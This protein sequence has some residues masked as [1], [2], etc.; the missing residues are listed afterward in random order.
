MIPRFPFRF[1][2]PRLITP[3]T[4]MALSS[5][6]TSAAEPFH[7][8]HENILGTSLDLQ[9]AVT[10]AKQATAA[11]AAVLGEIERL[12]RI[13]SGYDPAS[14]LSR[15]NTAAQPMTYSQEMIDVL[16]AYDQW[17]LKSHGAYN[18][19][20][21]DLIALWTKAEKAGA[22]PT[23]AEL[24]PV[25]TPL[26]RPGWQI[27]A[28]TRTVVR[29]S[30][31]GTLNVNSLGKG[32][33]VTKAAVAARKV[34]PEGAGLLVN[35]G[36][37]IFASGHPVPETPWEIGVANPSHNE[38]NSPPL[39]TVHL[40]NQ[41]VSTS[42]AYE[43]GFNIKGRHYSH[44]LDPRS[45]QATE[46][47]ASATVVA[48]NNASSNAMAT[49]LCV[50]KPEE[51]L[52]LV[53][54]YPGAEC[55]IIAADGR[56]LRSPGFATLES[57]ATRPPAASGT[58]SKTGNWPVGYQVSISLELK[59]SGSGGKREKPPF[60]A[61]WAENAAGE[62]VRTIAV[63]G[64]ERKYL[65]E[66]RAWWKEAKDN[67]EW[68]MSITR[69]TRNSGQYRLAW[70]GMDDHNQPLPPGTYT[71]SVEANREHGTYAIKQGQIECGKAPAV[72]TISAS[73]EFSETKLTFG[74]PEKQS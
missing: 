36:G 2:L 15:L 24:Q 51:G 40:V 27:S 6:P 55:L 39:I 7:F 59:S 14:E 9:V 25:L 72:G 4:V 46:G 64:K 31:P 8:H 63:W 71:I 42:A 67:Q 16:N 60:V 57:T 50:L 18:G 69:A 61:V 66:L 54:S 74:P 26:A 5:P 21:G 58:L 49:T 68:A 65:T 19:H 35:I 32:Y 44:I 48:N 13:L 73:S 28:N 37:D 41:A 70:D 30:A 11:E 3:I 56:Q 10:D 43:R 38:D 47:V 62:R 22:P 1:P 17:Q 20:L 29:L 53:K 45:G 12:R 34:L 52:Q 33:I 23:A